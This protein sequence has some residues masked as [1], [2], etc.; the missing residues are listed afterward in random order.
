MHVRRFWQELRRFFQMFGDSSRNF[1]GFSKCSAIMQKLRRIASP[2]QNCQYKNSLSG[3][4]YLYFSYFKYIYS[5]SDVSTVTPCSANTSL[6]TD[7]EFSTLGNP[8]YGIK[9]TIQP[10]ISSG[11]NPTESPVLT[12]MPI[13]GFP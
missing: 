8:T 5:S 2:H 12:C 13:C 9:W 6:A 4:F 10:T 11:V 1:G 7:K 3:C